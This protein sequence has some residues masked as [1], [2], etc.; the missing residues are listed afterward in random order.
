MAVSGG[1]HW[2]GVDDGPY[3]CMATGV[4]EFILPTHA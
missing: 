4:E 1:I 3:S 2:V